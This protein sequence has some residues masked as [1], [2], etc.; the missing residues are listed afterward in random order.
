MAADDSEVMVS[1][2]DL[3]AVVRR[4]FPDVDDRTAHSLLWSCTPFPVVVDF[5]ELTDHLAEAK[6][7]S[8]GTAEGAIE[9]AHEELDTQF[10]VMR[11]RHEEARDVPTD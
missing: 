9:W 2:H 1:Y 8:D 5:D 7:M 11:G 6:V 10:D 4:V 3:Y